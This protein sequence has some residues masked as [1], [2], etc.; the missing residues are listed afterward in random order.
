LPTFCFDLLFFGGQR[1]V[2]KETR[3]AMR[4]AP[5]TGRFPRRGQKLAE[6]GGT[7][8]EW[9]S[10]LFITSGRYPGLDP[11]KQFAPVIREN[12]PPQGRIATGLPSSGVWMKPLGISFISKAIIEFQI[13]SGT[14]PRV[15]ARP[16]P[17]ENPGEHVSTP[18][19]L[20]LL[21]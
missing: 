15:A 2:T 17:W 5:W 16:P 9:V 3:P 11:L 6:C 7:S 14:Y 20:R 19:G 21:I 10:I 4:T 12:H 8:G 1:K 13:Y 18:T